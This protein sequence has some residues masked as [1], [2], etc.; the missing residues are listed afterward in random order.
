MSASQQ[1][2]LEIERVLKAEFERR[3][4]HVLPS[5][6]PVETVHTARFDVP[7]Y[8]DPY[9]KGIPTSIKSAK[10]RHN[11][12][13]VYLADALRIVDLANFETTRLMVALYEQRGNKKFFMEVREYLITGDEWETLTG[14]V[15]P[16]MLVE[17]SKALKGGS[18]TEARLEA[19]QWKLRMR[20]LFP[21]T[22]MRWNAK[23]DSKNQR[24]LQCSLH[25]K[26]LEAVIADKSRIRVFGA[27]ADPP[28]M[29]RPPFLQPISRHVWGQG[30]RFP[31]VLF[32]PPRARQRLLPSDSQPSPS[33]SVP[34]RTAHKPGRLG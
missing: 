30:Q 24:R 7:G 19:R 6:L 18:A 8:M 12:A 15:P 32:S 5:H 9:G 3:S 1:H 10:A 21:D 4:R 16:E 31:L 29:V 22:P 25:L 34:S 13:L 2:G 28:G 20:E 17:Y 33:P 23:I 26:D 27:P 14:G 11:N